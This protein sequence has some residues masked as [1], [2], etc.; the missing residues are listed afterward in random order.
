MYIRQAIEEFGMTA[1]LNS[2]A[3]GCQKKG[4]DFHCRCVLNKKRPNVLRKFIFVIASE[5]FTGYLEQASEGIETDL[6]FEQLVLGFDL[7]HGT[8]YIS[9]DGTQIH[10]ALCTFAYGDGIDDSFQ[11][12]I[13]VDRHFMRKVEE[14]DGIYSLLRLLARYILKEKKAKEGELQSVL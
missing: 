4:G 14:P 6:D 3:F 12:L 2:L 11:K 10:N 1:D 8:Y 7:K 13:F 9:I 5:S